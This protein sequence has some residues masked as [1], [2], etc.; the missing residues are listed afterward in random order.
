MDMNVRKL[1]AEA[2]VYLL[3]PI[4]STVLLIPVK[5]PDLLGVIQMQSVFQTIA[6]DVT[7]TTTIQQLG[8]KSALSVK[9]ETVLDIQ[10]HK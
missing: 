10:D 2:S 4:L 9:K 1:P 3:A 7:E 5:P 8:K 6:V